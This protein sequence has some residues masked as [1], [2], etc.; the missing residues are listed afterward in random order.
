MH[1]RLINPQSTAIV[2][3]TVF[4]GCTPE[5]TKSNSP[6][7]DECA[8]DNGIFTYSSPMPPDSITVAEFA[9][10]DTH[11]FFTERGTWL[12]SGY[13]N[14]G[15]IWKRPLDAGDPVVLATGEILPLHIAVDT[16][17]IYWTTETELRKMPLSGGA[18]TTI[19]TGY[20]APQSIVAAGE[21]VY[22]TA[23]PAKLVRAAIAGG[24]VVELIDES[25]T[26]AAFM[27]LALDATHLYWA[28]RGAVGA[29]NGSVLRMPIK[30]GAVTTLA[31]GQADPTQIA[32]G[33]THVYWTNTGDFHA[34]VGLMRV[35]VT[36]GEAETVVSTQSAAYAQYAEMGGVFVDAENLYY[37][38]KGTQEYDHY[39]GTVMRKPLNGGETTT[40]ASALRYVGPS[41]AI[42]GC[43]VYFEANGKLHRVSSP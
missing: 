18:P 21:Y 30:G 35:P 19:A 9:L 41:L 10:N 14:D 40:L 5:A 23:S 6:V 3:A 27:G 33:T 7:P 1:R 34:D 16:E 31:T 15:R 24:D 2:I 11:S 13:N 4:L 42:R 38:V 29:G 20:G 8:R 28:S 36:G 32:V 37:T 22:F 39:D 25:A 26:N 12:P 43:H 17:N